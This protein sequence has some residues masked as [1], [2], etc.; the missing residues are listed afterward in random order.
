[1]ALTRRP[2]EQFSALLLFGDDYLNLHSQVADRLGTRPWT[3][4]RTSCSEG[5]LRRLTLR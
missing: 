2:P 1:M 3:I 4:S 5:R